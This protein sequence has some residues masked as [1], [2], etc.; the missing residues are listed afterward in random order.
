[1]LEGERNEG[2]KLVE[3]FN[4]AMGLKGDKK[5]VQEVSARP[6]PS[7]LGKERS[8]ERGFASGMG[9]RESRKKNKKEGIRRNPCRS[10]DFDFSKLGEGGGHSKSSRRDHSRGG[11]KKKRPPKGGEGGVERVPSFLEEK[12]AGGRLVFQTK[13]NGAG[14]GGAREKNTAKV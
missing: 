12:R 9:K 14:G 1:M 2:K 13:K 7:L 6:R 3:F 11:E 10:G 4:S 8:G 5:G